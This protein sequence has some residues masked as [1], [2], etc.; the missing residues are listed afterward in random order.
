MI[1]IYEETREKAGKRFSISIRQSCEF[2]K[3]LGKISVLKTFNLF[4]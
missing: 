2:D 3:K 4:F 1:H